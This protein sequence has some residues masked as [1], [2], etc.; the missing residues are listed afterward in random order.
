MRL[1]DDQNSLTATSWADI[2]N[3]PQI[4]FG[5]SSTTSHATPTDDKP[6]DA[7]STPSSGENNDAAQNRRSD[8]DVPTSSTSQQDVASN[9]HDPEPANI[10]WFRNQGP[11]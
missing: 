9:G 10:S 11:I 5:T 7:G 1:K 4:S 2:P 6:S 3:W 8:V